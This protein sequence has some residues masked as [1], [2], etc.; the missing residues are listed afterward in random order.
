MYVSIAH[1]TSQNCVVNWVMYMFSHSIGWVIILAFCPFW[2]GGDFIWLWDLLNRCCSIILI[3]Q[4][5]WL[6][7][8]SSCPVVCIVCSSKM[9]ELQCH[10][11]RKIVWWTRLRF[12]HDYAILLLMAISTGWWS[13][14]CVITIVFWSLKMSKRPSDLITTVLFNPT[15]FFAV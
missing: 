9:C 10:K 7:F 5:L 3:P 4:S 12:Y 14:M 11:V 6:C 1:P 15:A 8:Q 2:L 13:L